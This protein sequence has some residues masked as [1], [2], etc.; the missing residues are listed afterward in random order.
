METSTYI[1]YIKSAV[2][3]SNNEHNDLHIQEA[4][5]RS[6]RFVIEQLQI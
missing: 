3:V 6:G 2:G 5:F 1:V 4:A